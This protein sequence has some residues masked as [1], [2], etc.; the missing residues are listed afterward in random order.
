MNQSR[1][2]L[3]KEGHYGASKKTKEEVA[4]T[5]EKI[6]FDDE[7]MLNSDHS[8]DEEEATMLHA[9]K[10][11]LDEDA[12]ENIQTAIE[13]SKNVEVVESYDCWNQNFFKSGTKVPILHLILV[14]H[15]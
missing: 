13:E 3:E 5:I 8:S 1:Q 14:D 4:P 11:Y 2:E 15:C 6:R 10:L 12:Q 9:A 7:Y